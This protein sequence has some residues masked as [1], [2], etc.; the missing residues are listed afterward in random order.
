MLVGADEAASGAGLAA[1]SVIVTGSSGSL[2]AEVTVTT[3]ILGTGMAL[4][5][6]KMMLSGSSNLGSQKGRVPEGGEK[7]RNI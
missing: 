5:G 6:I 2:T 3:A 1:T 4:H 7:T